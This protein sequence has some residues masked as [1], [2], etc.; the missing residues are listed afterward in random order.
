[1]PT[2]YQVDTRAA[3]ATGASLARLAEPARAAA[4]EVGSIRLAPGALVSVSGE[5]AA[6]TSVWADDL[7]AVGASFD[8]LGTAVASASTAYETT[9]AQAKATFSRIPLKRT[10]I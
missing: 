7:R 1:M 10:E 4:A 5:L 3:R 8:H 9:D 6:F 2:E